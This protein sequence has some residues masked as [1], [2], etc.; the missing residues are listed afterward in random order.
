MEGN[1]PLSGVRVLDFTWIVAGP[2][3]TR[4]LADFGAEVIR[5]EYEARLDGG[6]TG[7]APPGIEPGPNSG[8]SFNFRNA[9]K[10]AITVN[11]NH[12]RGMDL[13]KRLIA[14]SDIV[15]ENFSSRIFEDWGLGYDELI[16]INPDVIYISLSG[17]GHTG[18]NHHYTTWGPTAQAVSGLTFM[19]G[20]PGHPPAGWGY[21]YMDHTAGYFG[22][23]AVLSALHYRIRTGQGQ[24]IDQSQVEAGI[25]LTG[26]TIL[27][28]VVNG[29]RSRRE[30]FPPGNRSIHPAIAPHNTYRCAGEDRW[31]VIACTNEE[32]WNALRKVMG[33][34]AWAS[35]PKFASALS[36]WENQDELDANIEQWT[37]NLEPR[38][39]MDIL[40]A[41]G[42]PAGMV[43]D[44]R[45]RMVD[46]PQLA[47]RGMF[48]EI[49]HPVLG[50]RPHEMPPPK[51]SKSPGW[52]RS[53]APLL[54]EHNQYV[55]QD[56]LGLSDEEFAELIG[57][58]VI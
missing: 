9:S 21:S 22:A 48:V 39:V 30:D 8:G 29:R 33:N 28:Y 17:F 32:Q 38:Q 5:V 55:Y 45:D 47:H 42:V 20:L 56:L 49:E 4:I 1:G 2:Q 6:R 24:R 53:G 25:V 37:S 10:K 26:P 11:I 16:K 12:P 31:C 34:P 18:R 15:I 40:Q 52:V 27:D 36:R 23:I 43:Q 3:T 54:G 51:L 57:D 44:A 7:N 58:F 14:I 41:A 50:R 35:D 19:S 46:D 13:V